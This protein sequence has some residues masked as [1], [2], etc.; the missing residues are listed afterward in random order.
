MGLLNQAGDL[1]VGRPVALVRLVAGVVA[2]PVALPVGAL[3]LDAGWALDVCVVE[4]FEDLT[5]W[6]LGWP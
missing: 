6:P 4:P 3:L 5:R 2:L 1:V